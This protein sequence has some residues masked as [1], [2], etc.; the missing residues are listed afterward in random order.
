MNLKHLPLL[1][2]VLCV[3]QSYARDVT[4]PG[5]YNDLQSAVDNLQNGDVIRLQAGNYLG[6]IK[7]NKAIS[8][9]GEGKE[10]T[11][12]YGGANYNDTVLFYNEVNNVVLKNLT[13][14]G[15]VV[16]GS[17]AIGESSYGLVVHQSKCELLNVNFQNIKNHTVFINGGRFIANNVQLDMNGERQNLQ[18]DIGFNLNN[19]ICELT[20]IKGLS[21]HVDHWIDIN[22]KGTQN[23]KVTIKDCRFKGSKLYWGDCIRIWKHT[24]VSIKNCQMYR[25]EGGAAQTTLANSGISIN[26]FQ[27]KVEVIGNKFEGLF[28]GINIYSVDALSSIFVRKNTFTN[29]SEAAVYVRKYNFPVL[30]LG[31]ANSTGDNQF[32]NPQGFDIILSNDGNCN[33]HEDVQAFGNTWTAT[34]PELKIW[35]KIDDKFT[36]KVI[37]NAKQKGKTSAPI[38]NDRILHDYKRRPYYYYKNQG[39]QLQ[40]MYYHLP[41]AIERQ[42]TQ[43]NLSNELIVLS[44]RTIG[45]FVTLK[46]IHLTNQI[47][48]LKRFNYKLIEQGHWVFDPIAKQQMGKIVTSSNLSA[49]FINTD[50]HQTK[51][52]YLFD[53]KMKLMTTKAIQNTVRQPIIYAGESFVLIDYRRKS[54][55]HRVL[56]TY[57]KQLQKIQ[58]LDIS[59]WNVRNTVA[60][61]EGVIYIDHTNEQMQRV[62][63]KYTSSFQVISD[64]VLYQAIDNIAAQ[65]VQT[66]TTNAEF[67]RIGNEISYWVN[68]KKQ[69]KY[70][71]SKGFE[72]TKLAFENNLA[73]VKYE[74]DGINYLG[75]F[76]E[77]LTF[78][79][80]YDISSLQVIDFKIGNQRV[81]ANYR[82]K[83]GGHFVGVFSQKMKY[84][85]QSSFTKLTVQSMKGSGG[86]YI[87]HYYFEKGKSFIGTFDI[88]MKYLGEYKFDNIT[89]LDDFEYLNRQ[90]VL[91]YY[92]SK[93]VKY[94]GYFDAYMK[95]KSEKIL[96]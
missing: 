77:K 62:R 26:G 27:N 61:N 60:V 66:S 4:V 91:H 18:S 10:N 40:T 52:I 48:S 23:C 38:I 5:D 51:S 45:N 42:E 17:T 65:E 72:V 67:R 31:T 2:F 1:F 35:D 46:S 12:I 28:Q 43:K 53:E 75:T 90:V 24:D 63:T 93:G 41:Q 71:F 44:E 58:T 92:N 15:G 74:K 20:N 3:W 59:G 14:S 69:Q 89:V 8:I 96:K 11:F 76:D 33:S 7:T 88:N 78:L 54:D 83:Q 95:Y 32:Q 6:S 36:G 87:V 39:S 34:N 80:E 64:S 85:G 25:T 21:G 94:E 70:S 37:F 49:T 9:Y 82:S 56:E 47:T 68:G 55:Y 73:V 84:L 81:I 30:D 22:S 79:G 86:I 13:I 57:N 16:N 29:C 19:A 50:N